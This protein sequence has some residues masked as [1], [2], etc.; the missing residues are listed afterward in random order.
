MYRALNGPAVHGQLLVTT[1]PVEVK[2]GGSRLEERVSISI[3]P[4]DGD[5]Y[6]GYSPS[7]SSTDGTKIFTSQLFIIEA[8]D[9]LPVYI[10]SES[11]TVD[12]RIT[13]AG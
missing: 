3:Q 13:E 9:T 6:Y 10:V 12:T 5:L 1:T 11:G 4:L 8:S 2:I 7:V